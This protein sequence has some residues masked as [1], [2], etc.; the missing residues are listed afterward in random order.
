[1]KRIKSV[2]V[3]YEGKLVGK[4]SEYRDRL[5]A[6]QYTQSWL[7]EGFSISPFSLPLS[8]KLYFSSLEPFDGLF[9]VFDDCLP[10]GWGMLLTDRM[11]RSWGIEPASVSNITRLSLLG[12][13]AKGALSFRPCQLEDDNANTD[14]DYDQLYE[15]CSFILADKD[16]SDLDNL[17]KMAGNS[18]G[19][20][21]KANVTIDGESWIMKFPSHFDSRDIGLQE[22]S[23]SL[24]AAECGI[25]TVECRL[26]PSSKTSG[27][28]ACK[29]F[30]RKPKNGRVHMI[31]A[32]GLLET[33]HRFP[34]LDYLHLLKL[35]SILTR[36][37]EETENMFRLMC[38]NEFAHNRDDHAKNFS[39]LYDDS[40]RSWYM[41]PAYDLTYSSSINGEHATTINGKGSDPSVEDMLNVGTKCG[42]D[43]RRCKGIL[44]SIKET[45]DKAKLF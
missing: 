3:L 11:L 10:D 18:G 26:L 30:D 6:F 7:S 37:M 23:Y 21:P 42:L 2:E 33:S 24:A 31:S 9:G 43:R 27:Y 32:V 38:F 17:Y 8:E 15:Q 28:F 35:T 4:L 14:V 13:N 20:R 34:N 22:Y 36:N 45:V 25:R 41:S 19:A 16:I 44:E 40:K 12:N 39:F 29:R 1:M 5:V